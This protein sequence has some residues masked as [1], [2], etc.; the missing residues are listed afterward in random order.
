[1]SRANK[2]SPAARSERTRSAKRKLLEIPSPFLQPDSRLLLLEPVRRRAPALCKRLLQGKYRKP[3]ILDCGALRYLFFNFG[4][5][6][7]LMHRDHPDAL[8]LPYT[9][10]MMTFLL[11]KPR[12][13]RILLLGLGGGSLAK[14]CY[15]CLPS[16]AITVL[17]I[18][19]NVLAL[20]EEFRVPS[21]NDRFQVLQ[22]DGV[23]YVAGKG[24]SK[25]VI[26]VDA[27]DRNGVAPNLVTARFYLDAKCRLSVSG[28]LVVNVFGDEYERLSHTALI[29][30]VFAE[31]VIALPVREYSNLIVLAFRSDSSLLNWERL[32][33]LADTLEGRLGLP[34]SHYLRKM[35]R[36][37]TQ[38]TGLSM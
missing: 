14:F 25:D 26:L 16:S 21:N 30:N 1:M 34:F 19:P 8:C 15:R 20:R 24:P 17:E 12:P 28:V 6:E 23:S 35:V 11:F 29:R 2:R 36:N 13:H 4:R 22:G 32:E 27:Y 18:D 37:I 38:P 33:P 7:S 5:I 10:K 3:F 31:R 9:K